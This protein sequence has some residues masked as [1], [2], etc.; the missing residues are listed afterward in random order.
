MASGSGSNSKIGR[1]ARVM[2]LAFARLVFS[3]RQVEGYQP[4]PF[5]P[6][7]TYAQKVC[8]HKVDLANRAGF[9]LTRNGFHDLLCVFESGPVSKTLEALSDLSPAEPEITL[10]LSPD[11]YYLRS[12]SLAPQLG[13]EL[14]GD[15]VDRGVEGPA[16]APVGT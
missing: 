14:L 12:R 13:E 4:A 1:P 11:S 16:K 15:P 3:L 5:G 10:Y 6:L 2:A 9:E 7:G 8:A